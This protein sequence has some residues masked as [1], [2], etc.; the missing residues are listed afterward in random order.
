MLA[1]VKAPTPRKISAKKR[2]GAKGRAAPKKRGPG[3]PR[4]ETTRLA[5]LC[6]AFE[7]V[8][9]RGYANVTS[10]QIAARA[11]AGK[12]TLY[13]W[14]D[15]KPALVLDALAEHGR[16]AIDVANAHAI[17]ASNLEEFLRALFRAVQRSGPTLRHLMAAAQSDASLR[18]ALVRRLIEPRRD[19]LRTL[20]E[21][22]FPA[23]A[24][25]EA[26]VAALYGAMWYRL[27]LDEPLDA[28]LA[29]ELAAVLAPR[30]RPV[31]RR[32]RGR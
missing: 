22:R 3:R 8:S 1:A 30:A 28:E 32:R 23:R 18:E 19:T 7:L 14:W 6:A 25:R 26:V 10:E 31:T 24:R 4:S 29:R 27:L 12:Q 9:E 11:G 15:S 21:K 2:R 13:R 17:A 16:S 5:L 20:L